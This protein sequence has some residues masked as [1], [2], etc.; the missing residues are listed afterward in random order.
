MIDRLKLTDKELMYAATQRCRCGAGMA[1]PLDHDLAMELRSWVCSA[2][3][4]GDV[5]DTA[6]PQGFAALRG[7]PPVGSHD[8]LDFAFFKVREET[9]INNRGGHTTRPAGTV[10]R[11]VGKAKCPQCGYTWMSDPYSACGLGHHW[12]PGPCPACSYAVGAHGTYNSREGEPIK[13][14]YPDVVLDVQPSEGKP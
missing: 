4:R 10:A 11:T 3:L 7:E 13:T 8:A 6:T 14:G 5:E 9:S 2:V 1:H 12:F